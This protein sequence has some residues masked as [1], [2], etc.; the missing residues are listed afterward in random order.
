MITEGPS[1]TSVFIGEAVN[2]CC[3]FI[4]TQSHPYWRINGTVYS[5]NILP[6][7]HEA[8]TNGI[9][10]PSATADQNYTEY[11]CFFS[12]YIGGGKFEETESLPA[13]VQV[14]PVPEV[15]NTVSLTSESC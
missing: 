3:K 2:L 1:N 12:I 7:G 9:Y 8:R 13:F 5:V 4:G 15:D 11:M 10:I 6:P 14:F